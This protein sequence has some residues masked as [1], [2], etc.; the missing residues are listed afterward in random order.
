LVRI[1]RDLRRWY[2]GDYA[3]YCGKS[4][5]VSTT[6]LTEIERIPVGS[7]LPDGH[8]VEHTSWCESIKYE[9]PIFEK[10]NALARMTISRIGQSHNVPNG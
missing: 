10:E 2:D 8:D 9:R 3:R 6:K 1:S 5:R 7:I 4:K